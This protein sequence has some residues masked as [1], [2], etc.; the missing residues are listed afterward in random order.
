MIKK[1]TGLLGPSQAL[2]Q[3]YFLQIIDRSLYPPKTWDFSTIYVTMHTGTVLDACQIH[4]TS[5][6]NTFFSI[7]R[8]EHSFIT[9]STYHHP[10]PSPHTSPSTHP[11]GTL[12]DDTNTL[13]PFPLVLPT[14]HTILISSHALCITLVPSAH[15]LHTS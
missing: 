8:E 13:T 7:H 1:T 6:V 3:I 9:P 15:H 14:A 12:P 11:H 2:V 10:Y 5:A 4:I